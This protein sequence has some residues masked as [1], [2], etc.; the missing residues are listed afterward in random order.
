MVSLN[1]IQITGNIVAN[2]ELKSIG[3][4]ED[5]VVVEG[6]IIHNWRLPDSTGSSKTERRAVIPFKVYGKSARRF[7]ETVTTKTNVLLVG[8]LDKRMSGKM[9][10][11]LGRSPFYEF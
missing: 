6:R 3:D 9:A 1:N 10:I 8:Y 2:P 5:S 4:G 7:A 11:S